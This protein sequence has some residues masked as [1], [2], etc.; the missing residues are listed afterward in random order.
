MIFRNGFFRTLL[1]VVAGF[2]TGKKTFAGNAPI[3]SLSSKPSSRVPFAGER[4]T[5][6]TFRRTSKTGNHFNYS[7]V[8]NHD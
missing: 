1:A 7:W 6:Y 8:K 2:F 4:W 3:F 5:G